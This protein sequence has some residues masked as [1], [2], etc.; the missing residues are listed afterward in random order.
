MLAKVESPWGNWDKY[1]KLGIFLRL[2][3]EAMLLGGKVSG[4]WRAFCSGLVL[5]EYKVCMSRDF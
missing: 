1:E 2:W 3:D 5:L 4:T